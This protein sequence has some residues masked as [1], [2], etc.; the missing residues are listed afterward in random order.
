MNYVYNTS[1]SFK[2]IQTEKYILDNVKYHVVL[3]GFNQLGTTGW[4]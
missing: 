3:K 1:T 2:T 4:M